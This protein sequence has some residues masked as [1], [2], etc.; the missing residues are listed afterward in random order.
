MMK[1][2][3]FLSIM[4]LLSVSVVLPQN[5]ISID[6]VRK[7][8]A[9]GVPLLLNQTV[10]VRGVVT[11]SRELGTPLV[12]F[13]VPIAGLVAYDAV[14]GAAVNRG[15]SVEVTGTVTHY[16]GLTEL[17]PVSAYTVLA[18]GV[19][20]PS[21][22]I[23]TPTQIRENSGE[24]YEGRLIRING[25]TQ[26]KTTSG[27]PATQW[28]VTSSG[29]NYRIF[30]GTDS[31][32]IRIYAS[33]NVANTTIPPYP[34]SVIALNSQ[35]KSAAPY[36]GGYQIIPRDLNDFVITA[37]GP[38]IASAPV[39][40]NITTNSVTLSFTTLTAGDTKIKY[41]LSDSLNQPEIYTDSIYIAAQSTEH[42]VTL[43][44]LKA[45]RIYSA[46]ISSTNTS[47]TSV[48]NPK[49]FSTAS[50]PAST[51]KIEVYFNFPVDTSVALPNNKANG[52][53]D[54]RIRLGNRIDSATYSIDMAMYSFN[55]ITI[56]RDKLINAMTRG[57]KIRVVYDHRDG[58]TQA[59]MQD[60]INAGVKVIQRPVSTYIMHNKF[61]VFDARDTSAHSKKWVWGGSA[62]ITNDQFFNDVQNVILIQDESLANTYTREFEEMWGSHNDNFN[63]SLAKFGSQKG[64]N[65]PHVFN[66]N[67]KRIECYFS[68][69]DNVSTKIENLIL[70]QTNKS[71]NFLIFAFTRFQIANRMKTKYNPPNVM[72][73]GVFDYSNNSTNNLYLEM[74][75]IGG[76]QPWNPAARVFLDTY[77][78]SLMHSKYMIIDA[79]SLSSNP[80][81][82]TGSF[83]YSEAA[84]SGND[85]NILIVYDS[86]IANQYYQDFVKKLK[87]AGGT[88]G[89]QK[90]AG[91]I[92][93]KFRIE[94]NYPNPFNPE[95][96]INVS[97]AKSS[98]VKLV[99]Y[100]VIGRETAVLIDKNIE[101]G[102]YNVKWVASGY[103][104]GV[105][106]V[107][108]VA[109]G[110][111]IDVKKMVLKK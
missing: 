47:G 87:D 95:T 65:T 109:D 69:S 59:L 83:N 79:D 80:V 37:G 82:E 36:F 68:P 45:G 98:Y 35:Y 4:I 97:I 102:T 23:L 53:T 101:A 24:L 30:V 21:P 34:F 44:N 54:Y 107:N 111:S 12:Y 11:T 74:K 77:S 76:S 14:F 92:P 71:I 75:G 51:G 84:T 6:S 55:E 103:P 91:I 73:R 81:V 25:I 2:V 8:D 108:L 90:I 9:N 99:I 18:T 61:F 32:D 66:I 10:K 48:Y 64:D 22:V 88:I 28:T 29:T 16:N 85:E 110:V 63:T 7:Q 41:F 13:Q 62:N 72:V 57:V 33:T 49:V 1:K 86:L 93:D 39:E 27:V 70:N 5:L 50:H 100:D 43:A 106:F 38:I 105:Y 78:N 3:I 104:S 67:G 96:N 17:Q 94:Q 19:T 26:V 20:T 52:N 60:L 46:Y 31:C 89:I 56:I 15:D 40:S 58:N 42:T